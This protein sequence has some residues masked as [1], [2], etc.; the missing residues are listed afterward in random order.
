MG[1]LYY[2][3]VGYVALTASFALIESQTNS[4]E[5]CIY[6]TQVTHPDPP[7][8]T[9]PTLVPLRVSNSSTHP[10]RNIGNTCRHNLL[11]KPLKHLDS[12]FCSRIIRSKNLRNLHTQLHPS[13]TPT[14]SL[15][16]PHFEP[17]SCSNCRHSFPSGVI[18]LQKLPLNNFLLAFANNLGWGCTNL[19]HTR[20]NMWGHFLRWSG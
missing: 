20:P 12:K 16:L 19:S 1:T 6:E 17:A 3:E 7:P 11:R 15:L 14:P 13:N 5:G 9:A 10:R 2:R 8:I 4:K 18:L